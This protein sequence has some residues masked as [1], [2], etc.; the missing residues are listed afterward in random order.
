M[1]HCCK[2]V[3]VRKLKIL[4]SDSSWKGRVYRVA[5]SATSTGP[6]WGVANRNPWT[7][8]KV[9]GGIDRR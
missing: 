8:A 4:K 3:R 1:I 7:K 6:F 9:V 5:F 2:E